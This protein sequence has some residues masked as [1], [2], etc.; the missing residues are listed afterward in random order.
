M[1]K[2]QSFSVLHLIS[3]EDLANFLE[4]SQSKFKKTKEIFDYVRHSIEN[5]SERDYCKQSLIQYVLLSFSKIIGQVQKDFQIHDWF[6]PYID[7]TDNDKKV[8]F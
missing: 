6:F 3:W 7:I 4:Q 1:T 5:C 8:Y 2:S